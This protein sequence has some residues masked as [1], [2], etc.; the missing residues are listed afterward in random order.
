MVRTNQIQLN[1]LFVTLISVL[2]KN[3]ANPSQSN[4]VNFE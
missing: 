1:S 4:T 3:Y 2:H